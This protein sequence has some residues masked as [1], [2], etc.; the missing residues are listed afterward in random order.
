M[1]FAGFV[2]GSMLTGVRSPELERRA[3]KMV[4]YPVGDF[5][6]R[7]KNIVIAGRREFEVDKTKLVKAVADALKKEGLL[8]EVKVKK[9]KLLVRIS[10]YRKEPAII[11]LKLVSKPGL[12][13][14]SGVDELAKRRRASILIL[15]TPKG[16]MSSKEALKKGVGGEVIAEIW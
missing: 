3:G 11:D 10:Y 8:E 6:I 5:L 9:G 2:L 16:V 1:D 15:S 7:I 4:N 14:Y 12:R 13:I